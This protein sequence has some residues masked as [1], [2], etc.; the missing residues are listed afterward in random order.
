M[1][2][3]KR[4][5]IVIMDKTRIHDVSR[6][7]VK[8]SDSSSQS[9]SHVIF[10]VEPVNQGDVVEDL[11]FFGMSADDE[12]ILNNRIKELIEKLNQLDTDYSIRNMETGK[13]YT[14]IASVGALY[15]EFDNINMIPKGTY[16][17]IDELKNVKTEFGYCKGYKPA[18]RP[19]E[20]KYIENLE[21]KSENIYL[22]SDSLENMQK[23][24]D[25]MSE[26]IMKIYPN[27]TIESKIFK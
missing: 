10:D 23:L 19:L 3:S 16:D 20:G 14:T 7:V 8:Y 27:F 21:I 9:S 12:S 2:V 11:I 17:K 1:S 22:F 18:F 13:F 26:K 24:I 4:L 25:Y 15:V 6:I 5:S